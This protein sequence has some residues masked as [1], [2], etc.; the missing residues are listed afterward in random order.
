MLDAPLTGNVEQIV[1]NFDM[2]G[3]AKAEGY[4]LSFDASGA[5]VDISGDVTI[6]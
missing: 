2:G 5:L 4:T 6:K 3:A 1:L